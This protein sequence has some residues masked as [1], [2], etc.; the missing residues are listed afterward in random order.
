MFPPPAEIA[1]NPV[2]GIKH[3]DKVDA[4]EDFQMN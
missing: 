2:E 4:A 3:S 1:L